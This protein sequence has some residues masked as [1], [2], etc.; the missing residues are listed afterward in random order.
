M[1]NRILN[2][3]LQPNQIGLFYL[4][5]V[6]FLLKYQNLYFA[7]DP[8]LTDYVDR[9]CCRETVIWNR[10]YPAPMEPSDLDFV[11]YVFCTHAHSDHADPDTLSVIARVNPK[12]KFLVS[13]AITN[14]IAACGIPAERI[15]GL[16]TDEPTVLT[17]D[18]QVT[19][20]PSAHEELHQNAHGDYE[21]VGF[22]FQF[23]NTLLYHSGD[24]CPYSG[25]EERVKGCHIMILPVN[26]R[27]Y[28]RTQ[29]Q[30]IIG[31]FTSREAI[32]LAKHAGARLLIPAHFDLYDINC[33]NP[34]Q[35]VDDLKQINPAQSFHMFTPGEGYV[36]HPGIL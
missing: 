16:P 33:L 23:G 9:N 32:L 2:T 7:V 11:D 28:Y 1:K 26:G 36:Y 10:R 29:V 35:F 15:V 27:D 34:A 20:I 5:Q 14:E 12:A 6:G 3:A 24:C 25:L 22:V 21:E 18:I 13:A 19:A 31:C 30:N 8:Y 17:N 4:G